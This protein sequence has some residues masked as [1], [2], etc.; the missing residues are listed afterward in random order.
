VRY[1]PH[2]RQVLG[3]QIYGAGE[4]WMNKDICTVSL[5]IFLAPLE[6]DAYSQDHNHE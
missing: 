4:I 3:R 6:I 1:P 2:I 5:I